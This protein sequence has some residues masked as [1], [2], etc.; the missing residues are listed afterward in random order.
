[1][2]G[3]LNK[4][5]VPIIAVLFVLA[6]VLFA[7]TYTVRFTELAV[8][9][10]FGKAGDGGIKTEPGLYF[11]WPYPIQSVTKYDK[12]VRIVKTR[13]E[14]QQTA[15]DFQI[16]VEG[17][18]TYRVVDPLL[19]FQSFSDAGDRAEDHFDKAERDVLRD[20][21]RSTLGET[22][23]YRM[24]EL[25]DPNGGASKL[26]ELEDRVLTLMRS[27]G[28]GAGDIQATYGVEIVSVGIDRIVLPE[29]TTT[30]VIERMGA[31]RDRLAAVYQSQGEAVARRIKA[32]A[33]SAASKI[34]Q[35]ALSRA[36]EI[37]A[38]GRREAAPYYSRI[39]EIDPELAVFLEQLDL[40]RNAYAKRA[41]LVWS[42]D[43]YGMSVFDPSLLGQLQH[44]EVPDS[45]LGKGT[46]GE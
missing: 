42:T 25:F 34:T 23:R 24:D 6:I 38:E 26:P 27:G 4:L 9:T 18:L 36:T 16:I 22:S 1:M 21:L 2:L 13:S 45:L 17:Y 33:D 40:L 14:T 12:R 15:D 10:T 37:R 19:F 7:T 29:D 20:R 11:K 46:P 3:T 44:G 43:D 31:N 39:Q 35:F 5:V 28:E 41:T 30:K 8:V 32:E